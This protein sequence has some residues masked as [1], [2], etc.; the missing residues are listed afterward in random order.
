MHAVGSSRD[1]K[2]IASAFT[3]YGLACCPSLHRPASCSS[4]FWVHLRG[5]TALQYKGT[6]APTFLQANSAQA[7]DPLYCNYKYKLVDERERKKERTGAAGHRSKEDN[8]MPK[9]TR[10]I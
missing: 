4:K 5:E 7:K 2:G 1:F 8:D 6:N 10:K 9:K 3:G